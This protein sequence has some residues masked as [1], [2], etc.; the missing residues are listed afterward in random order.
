VV[1]QNL[2]RS[3]CRIGIH[4]HKN[5]ESAQHL[6]SVLPESIVVQ[7]DLSKSSE[8]YAIAAA[9]EKQWGGCLDVLINNAAVTDEKLCLKSSE[10]MFDKIVAVN[11]RGPAFMTRALAPLMEKQGGGH[12]INIASLAG[13]KGRAGLGAYSASKAGLIGLTKA[14]AVELADFNIRVNAVVPGYLMTQMGKQAS[15]QAKQQALKASLLHRYGDQEE[16]ACFIDYLIRTE[17]ITG[18]V[19]YL[20]S[21]L[22]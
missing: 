21:R 10:E 4:C 7:A 22:V 12:V 18:Q 19:F 5:L 13:T 3:G 14:L 9:I 16:V 15:T 11:L 2:A 8:I 20:D 17:S 6:A 1:A